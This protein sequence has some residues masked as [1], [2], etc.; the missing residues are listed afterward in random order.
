MMVSGGEI[1]S[2]REKRKQ[3]EYRRDGQANVKRDGQYFVSVTSSDQLADRGDSDHTG[4][5][6]SK[7]SEVVTLVLPTIQSRRDKKSSRLERRSCLSPECR[8]CWL[9]C[10]CLFLDGSST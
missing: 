10:L 9:E 4:W 6:W 7:E 1:E 3:S 2:R 8:L 5:I